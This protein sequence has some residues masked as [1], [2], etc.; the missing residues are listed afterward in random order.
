MSTLS[1]QEI[2]EIRDHFEFF[3]KNHNDLL[4]QKEFIQLFNI[5][6]PDASREMAIRGFQTI[7]EDGNGG[8][9]FEEFLEWW[10]MNWTV[11]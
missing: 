1:E 5:L 8:I 9:D 6:A 10:Q 4:E 3:D 2:A 7:D 11:F